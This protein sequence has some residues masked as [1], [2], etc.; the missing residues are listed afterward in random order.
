VSGATYTHS[1]LAALLDAAVLLYFVA[2]GLLSFFCVLWMGAR[3][4][5]DYYRAEMLQPQRSYY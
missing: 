3:T 1:E 4:E 5:R 2:L